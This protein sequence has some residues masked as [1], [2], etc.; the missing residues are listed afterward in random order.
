MKRWLV[1]GAFV[2]GALAGGGR[3]IAD[4]STR[5]PSNGVDLVVTAPDAALDA[6]ALRAHLAIETHREVRRADAVA[7]RA[8][9]TMI[10]IE[11]GAGVLRA[12][13]V[14]GGRADEEPRAIDLGDLPREHR[15]R[16][17][18]LVLAEALREAP[19]RPSLPSAPPLAAPDA[20]PPAPP[21]TVK[22]EPPVR[23]AVGVGVGARGFP[24]RS[25]ALAELRAGVELGL[26][27]FEWVA[28][29][30]D[31]GGA[32]GSR[33]DALGSVAMSL[34]TASAAPL[35]RVKVWKLDVVGG[36]GFELGLPR[37][38]AQ[39][40]AGAALREVS[41]TFS[42]IDLRAA[43]RAP[44][45]D[46]AFVGADARIGRVLSELDFVAQSPDGARRI[47]GMGGV[48]LGAHAFIGLQ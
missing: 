33:D 39:A 43:V 24:S 6:E 18:A 1:A 42:M 9:P 44:L 48:G 13:I 7:A 25:T 27:R 30:V 23:F 20:T 2:A 34:L 32:V 29:Q 38:R 14:R 12:R 46:V 21:P 40:S 16:V 11:G 15:A 35:A 4:E 5:E 28:L 8:A 31:A 22:T 10:V 3:A 47:A 36:P 17:V 41:G 37:A 45:G 19:A 26:H